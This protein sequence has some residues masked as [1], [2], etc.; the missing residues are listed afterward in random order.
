[1][2]CSRGGHVASTAAMCLTRA[3]M[4]LGVCQ[5]VALIGPALA[6]RCVR[7]RDGCPRDRRS[8]PRLPSMP[9]SGGTRTSVEPVGC[10]AVGLARKRGLLGA[11][12]GGSRRGGGD[13]ATVIESGSSYAPLCAS[14]RVDP[15]A[16][17]RVT[18]ALAVVPLTSRVA[19][20]GVRMCVC[21]CIIRTS[22]SLR[23]RPGGEARV[24]RPRANKIRFFSFTLGDAISTCVSVLAE[25]LTFRSARR[26]RRRP[27][28]CSLWP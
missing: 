28:S 6:R 7:W 21:V 26:A 15:V 8:L 10:V 22:Y 12:A 24:A 18:E 2:R 23:I 4:A 16:G 1:M 14:A 5:Q 13:D 9:T 3:S 27:T 19:R 25:S 17:C 11:G 20:V